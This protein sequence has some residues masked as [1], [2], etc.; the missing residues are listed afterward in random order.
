M[1]MTPEETRAFYRAV[2]EVSARY[3]PDLFERIGHEV[4]L[5]QLSPKPEEREVAESL[6]RKLRD[7]PF[8]AH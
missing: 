4:H 5:L 8:T 3:H 2:V 6:L 7:P 1:D